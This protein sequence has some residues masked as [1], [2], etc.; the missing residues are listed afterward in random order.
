MR[1]ATDIGMN[2]LARRRPRVNAFSVLLRE[3]ATVKALVRR[4]AVVGAVAGLAYAA[5][6]ILAARAPDTAGVTYEPQPFPMP[7][8]P[9]PPKAR[10][11]A[12]VES[13]TPF[14]EPGASGDCPLSHPIKGKL[15]SGIY[16]RPGGFMYDRTH[17]DRC[18]RDPA[19]AE[20][21]GL[22]AA[23]R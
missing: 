20:A 10:V 11:E 1:G 2:S 7:P 4:G 9:V 8:K 14:V 13:S 17:A 12:E 18:F 23:K 19:A 16:H 6:K 5:W 21:E 22:R 3:T 15:T